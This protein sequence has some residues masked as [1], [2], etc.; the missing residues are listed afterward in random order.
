[1]SKLRSSSRDTGGREKHQDSEPRGGKRGHPKLA[2]PREEHPVVRTAKNLSN[3]T[4][5]DADSLRSD[6]RARLEQHG[7]ADKLQQSVAS[8]LTHK[9]AGSQ[10]LVEPSV[11]LQ[12]LIA[13]NLL[14]DSALGKALPGLAHALRTMATKMPEDPTEWLCA[15]LKASRP[16]VVRE[17]TESVRGL[18]LTPTLTL[19]LALARTPT[20]TH[21]RCSRRT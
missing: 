1:V 7:V 16:V 15:R 19:T 8:A 17:Y 11:E 10:E 9:A 21:T 14:E 12:S 20:R 4:T 6:L 5:M 2:G 13:A 3:L 18:P